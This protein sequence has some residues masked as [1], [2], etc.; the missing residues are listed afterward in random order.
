MEGGF[1]LGIGNGFGA[2]EVFDWGLGLGGEGLGEELGRRGGFVGE[3][4]LTQIS[5]MILN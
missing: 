1:G 2:E 4:E 3:E 5:H